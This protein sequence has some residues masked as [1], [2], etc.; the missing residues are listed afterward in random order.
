M[1]VVSSQ[2]SSNSSKKAPVSLTIIN[3]GFRPDD[4]KNSK[5]VI[6]EDQQYEITESERNQADAAIRS[7]SVDDFSSKVL[8]LFLNK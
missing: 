6:P 1:D 2:P 4:E 3:T 7:E 8:T 5:F